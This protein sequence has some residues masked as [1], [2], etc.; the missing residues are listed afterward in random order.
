MLSFFLTNLERFK[1]VEAEI[2]LK[3]LLILWLNDGYLPVD[4][5]LT[6]DPPRHTRYRSLV[7]KAFSPKRVSDM[8]PEIEDKINYIIDQFYDQGKCDVS[9]D[10]AQQLPVR[11]IA[12][13][14]GVPLEDYDKFCGWSDAFVQQLSGTSSSRRTH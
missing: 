5:M 6:A 2:I 7:D 1:E 10:I 4:T 14:L 12:E 13:Q 3:K 11:V 8:G 9:R